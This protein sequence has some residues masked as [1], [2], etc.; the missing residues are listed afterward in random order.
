MAMIEMKTKLLVRSPVRRAVCRWLI[1]K[2]S[3]ASNPRRNRDD[4]Q[5]AFAFVAFVA[6][7]DTV[8]C[9]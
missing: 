1:G 8:S 6:L 4:D 2:V 3:R 9:L 7:I 5:S